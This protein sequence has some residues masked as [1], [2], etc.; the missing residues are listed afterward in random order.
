M[1]LKTTLIH[2]NYQKCEAK[3]QIT[4]GDDYSVPDG[5]PDI[6]SIL[7][8]KAEVCVEEVHTEKG[9]IK[10]RGS[11]KMWVLYLAERSSDTANCLTMDF[12][13]DET[14]YME[15]AVTGDNLKI[16]WNIEDL[17]VTI[18]H[19]GKLSVRALVSIYGTVQGI[20]NHQVTENVEEGPEIHVRTQ[21]FT[22]AEPVVE[23]RESYRIKD[24]IQLPVNKPNVQNVLWRNMQI[25]GMDIRVQEGRLAL[26]GEVLVLIVYQGEEEPAAIQ[27]LE[28]TVPFHGTLDVAGLAPEMFGTIE[29]EISRQDMELKPDYD[30]ELRM[31]QLE[32]LLDIHL[33]LYEE[34]TLTKLQ[35]VYS[36][37]EKLTPVVE[38][39]GYEKL[40]M[41]NQTK[42][43]ISVQEKLEEELKILQILGHQ[44]QLQNKRCRMTEGGLLCEG[45]AE[46]QVLYV[47]SNDRQPFGSTVLSIPYSQLIEIPEIQKNDTWKVQETIDQIFV[48]MPESHLMEARGTILLSACIMEQCRMENIT[49][50]NAEDYDLELY[51]KSPGMMIHFVQPGENLWQIAKSNR[52]TVEGIKKLNDITAD[53]VTPGQKLLLLKAQMEPAIV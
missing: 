28:Q 53:E 43:R 35:D 16:D 12:P 15:G 23:K 31:F 17:R 13:F 25:R 26:K 46:V 10:M 48:T 8:K 30:G 2:R 24:E 41:C 18:V 34:R 21:G 27:W 42:C 51:K 6:A 37:R 32:M 45:T 14:L 40:R 29:T 44:A 38:D 7:Q 9:K 33:H 3:T 22:M 11:L 1:E 47:T 49:G 52:T 20:E 5:K 4:I 19:L 39:I 50:V 36:T